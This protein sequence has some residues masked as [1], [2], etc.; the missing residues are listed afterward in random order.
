[1]SILKKQIEELKTKNEKLEKELD[2]ETKK[3]LQLQSDLRDQK[4]SLTSAVIAKQRIERQF[5]QQKTTINQLESSNEKLENSEQ[6]CNRDLRKQ[7]A[8]LKSMEG[9]YN[10]LMKSEFYLSSN[11]FLLF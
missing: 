2:A 6:K 10:L 8:S 11:R 9:R 5:Y 1:M 4:T 7:K 3:S